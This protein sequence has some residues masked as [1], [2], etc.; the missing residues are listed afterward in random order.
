MGVSGSSEPLHF[1][2]QK[3]EMLVYFWGIDGKECFEVDKNK[4]YHA[5]NPT[6][7]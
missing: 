6:K 4:G 7:Y 2:G 1:G 5:V 3:Y